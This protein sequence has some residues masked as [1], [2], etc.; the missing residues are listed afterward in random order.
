MP[1]GV[2]AGT[3]TTPLGSMSRGALAFGVN[4]TSA[5]ETGAPLKVS[6]ASTLPALLLPVAPSIGPKPSS[7]ASSAA[8]AI[9]ST[10]TLPVSQIDGCATWQIW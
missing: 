9:T 4:T 5:S 3:E 10:L 7:T 8:S 6:F 1:A 2:P